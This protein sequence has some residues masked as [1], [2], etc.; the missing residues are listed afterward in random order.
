MLSAYERDG[1]LPE[2]PSTLSVEELLAQAA[3]G[4]YL[5]IMAYVHQTPDVDAALAALR[6][7]VMQRHA[8]A[9]TSGYGPRFLHSTGQL[10]KGGP[11][12]DCSC[13]S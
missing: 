4:D 11:P 13:K 3:P 9:T 8:I 12:A 10:H 2:T 6:L 7:R 5:C 1:A